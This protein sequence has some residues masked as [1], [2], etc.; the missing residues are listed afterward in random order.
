VCSKLHATVPLL[1]QKKE[2]GTSGPGVGVEYG[3]PPGAVEASGGEV[4]VQVPAEVADRF[5]SA[6]VGAAAGLLLCSYLYCA[7]PGRVPCF[8][9]FSSCPLCWSYASPASGRR[10]VWGGFF[11]G[12]AV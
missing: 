2:E 4:Q 9:T 5:E 1:L 7:E 11:R 3:V 6:K 12:P 8:P 10:P